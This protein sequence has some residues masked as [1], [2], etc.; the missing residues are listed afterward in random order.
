M[1]RLLNGKE[2]TNGRNPILGEDRVA[3]SPAKPE[4]IGTHHGEDRTGDSARR[5]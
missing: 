2:T 4:E 5:Q 1:E 3:N